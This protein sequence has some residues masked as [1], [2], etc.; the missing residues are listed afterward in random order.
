MQIYIISSKLNWLCW[1][2][3]TVDSRISPCS[4]L[5]NRYA[6]VFTQTATTKIFYNQK[7]CQ[8]FSNFALEFLSRQ[9]LRR[10]I[11]T[12][13]H[14]WTAGQGALPLSG[15]SPWRGRCWTCCKDLLLEHVKHPLI[16]L[17]PQAILKMI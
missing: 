6:S 1:L 16:P 8:I 14:Q 15:T 5:G 3:T 9:T 4:S 13:G 7:F 12:E 11:R 2:F 17:F 10:T